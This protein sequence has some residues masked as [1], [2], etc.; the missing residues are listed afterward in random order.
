M[1]NP[2]PNHSKQIRS[3]L[4]SAMGDIAAH[5]AKFSL[6]TSNGPFVSL[7]ISLATA[8]FCGTPF[9]VP[10][11]LSAREN[12][13]SLDTLHS[14]YASTLS[15]YG[16]ELSYSTIDPYVGSPEEYQEDIEV[17]PDEAAL[18]AEGSEVHFTILDVRAFT[19]TLSQLAQL[20]SSEKEVVDVI[21]HLAEEVYQQLSNSESAHVNQLLENEL[22]ASGY[23]MLALFSKAG[24]ES[25]ILFKIAQLIPR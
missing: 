23:E 18:K 9:T 16:L 24:I 17:T 11:E 6:S 4:L 7:C 3:H 21:S 19:R 12:R 2:N 5:N 14:K 25:T 15:R 10:S 20:H 13:K 1:L 8:E 22:R